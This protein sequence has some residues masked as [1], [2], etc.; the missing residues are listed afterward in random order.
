MR[1]TALPSHDLGTLD[2]PLLVFG[3]P[4]SNLRATRA[5]RETAD[6]LGIPA[7]NVICTGDV[8]A[9]GA[10]PFETTALIMD[11]GVT[12]VMGNCEESFGWEADDCGC[13]FAEGTDCDLMSRSWYAY[14]HARL[15]PAQRAWMRGL[16]GT[17]T[18]TL[19]TRRFAVVHGSA[20]AINEFV[21]EATD[22]A[23]KT[24][25][26]DFLGVE[27]V[28]GGHAGVPFTQIID[29]RLW[30]NAGVIGMPA[31]DATPRVWF[32]LLHAVNGAV[33][34]ETHA[35][36]YDQVAAAA[37]MRANGLPAGYAA[38]LETGL[39]PNMDV[40]PEMEKRN[41]GQP[42]NPSPVLWAGTARVAAE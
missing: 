19:A 26:F 21:F 14:A 29:G 37:D 6:R 1:D 23:V 11:W 7:A 15:A 20:R 32:S 40:M 41:A 28:I 12:T 30:H 18:F 9:Y 31:N 36:G 39:W 17:V 13:G 5:M 4:Y 35:L 10:E 33:R 27:A 3:G 16:P 2:G 22:D 8:V 24:D 42:L 38:C 34:I 25:G